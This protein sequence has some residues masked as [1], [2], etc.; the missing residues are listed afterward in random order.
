MGIRDEISDYK[1]NKDE[2][3]KWLHVKGEEK[4]TVFLNVLK[5]KN[6]ETTWSNVSGL[7]RY[8]KRLLVNNSKYLSFFE[9]YC[10]SMLIKWGK[11]LTIRY[12]CL[13]SNN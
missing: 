5:E 13:H 7:F 6:I 2:V 9:E 1:E 10:R 4:Y 12:S 3:E 8:D 11:F